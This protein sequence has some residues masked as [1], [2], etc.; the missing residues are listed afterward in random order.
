M[1]KIL[2]VLLAVLML[3]TLAACGGNGDDTSEPDS[4]KEN[5]ALAD[6][7]VGVIVLHNETV[8]YDENFMIAVEAAC[9]ELGIDKD[10]NL[11]FKKEIYEDS[12]CYDACVELVED[13]C[14]LVF[15]DS[16]RLLRNIL[17]F[18]SSM[19]QVTTQRLL[20]S[21]TSTMHSLQSMK[22]DILQVLSLVSSS[23][24]SS[25]TVQSQLNRLSS[26]TSQLSPM[27]NVFQV[28]HHTISALRAYAPA[29]Q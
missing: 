9:D 15:A 6:L 14:D 1:K 26:V 4:G 13:G 16:S 3:F 21:T 2:A 5:T 10:K 12:S 29:Q 20:I 28:T 7:K 22:A 25:K 23:T 24:N 17:M 19:Q 18:S 27:L 8:G 11:L